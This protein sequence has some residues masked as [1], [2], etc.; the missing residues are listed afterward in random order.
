MNYKVNIKTKLS[1]QFTILVCVILMVFIS[2]VYY[3]SFDSQLSKF[4]QN[5]LDRAQNTA[6]LLINVQE[7]DSTLLKKIYQTTKSLEEEEIV[8]N[9]NNDKM[10]FS[11]KM[12]E[13]KTM[14]F[15]QSS[16]SDNP[17]YFT[18]G[19]KDGV[20]YNHLF[21]NQLYHVYVMAYDKYRAENLH[22]LR[23]VLIWSI[24]F[25]VCF[26]VWASYF[27]SRI[28]IKPISSIIT[29]VKEINLSKLSN[30]LDEGKR[31]DEI[32]QLAITFNQMLSDLELVFK[33]QDEFVS[34]ASHE[35][36]TP[37]A[38]M[39]AESDYF[40][41]RKRN[42][43]EY[44]LH[45]IRL[46]DDLRRLN[47]LINSL[48]ELAHLNRDKNISLSLL[49]IDELVFNAIHST[50]IKYPGRKILPKIEYSDNENDLIIKGNSG[51]LEIAFKNLID[52]AIKFSTRDVEVKISKPGKIIVVQVKD[53]GVGIPELEIGN[54]F[55]PFNRATNVKF[56]GGF[57]IGLS[58]VAKIMELHNAKINVTSV[59]NKGTCFELLFGS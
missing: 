26:S 52:N 57:G 39:I 38:I 1:I 17:E 2:L 7:V 4:R 48:L 30:R 55:K 59:L 40:I 19:K 42:P 16:H 35:L 14:I 18:I 15:S 11:D 46:T 58:I 23:V 53:Y 5:L 51:L 21:N 32:E 45:I 31:K 20:L 13:L 54:I 41:S 43:E 50:K 49:R 47:L 12:E 22:G 24:L 44:E 9:D 25:I 28:A 29:K 27:F 36:R 34:N 33:S 37:L 56:I 6:I 8:L 10:L 3:F